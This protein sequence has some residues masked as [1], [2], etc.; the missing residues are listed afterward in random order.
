MGLTKA[1]A[2][3]AEPPG[4]PAAGPT[5]ERIAALGSTDS[6]VRRQA[7]LDLR[8]QRSAIAALLA[9]YP[10]EPDPAT[11]EALFTVLAEFDDLDVG[12]AFVADL[13]L[14]D[15]VTRNAAAT[16][17]N[18][19]PG[20]VALLIDDLL[21]APSVR[22][23]TM[24]VTVL[25]GLNHPGVAGWLA[26]VIRQESDENVVAAALDAALQAGGDAPELIGTA[27]AR[28][29]ANPYLSFLAHTYA[30]SP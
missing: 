28:F 19:M 6:Q 27:L 25:T 3:P 8:N 21:Q 29:P 26:G 7:V 12:R 4:P 17:L 18:S 14:E 23:R 20:A 1:H 13:A 10:G 22:A 16:A 2:E 5:Q 24:A 11:R 15:A 9:A 30:S